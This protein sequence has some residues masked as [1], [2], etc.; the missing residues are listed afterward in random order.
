MVLSWGDMGGHSGIIIVQCIGVKL[1]DVVVLRFVVVHRSHWGHTQE[2][3]TQGGHFN[4]RK[5]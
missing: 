4:R 1:L 5:P 2:G 3:H